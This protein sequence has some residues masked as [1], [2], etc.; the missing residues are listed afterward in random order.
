[1]KNKSLVFVIIVLFIG[2]IECDELE[3]NVPDEVVFVIGEKKTKELGFKNFNISTESD[4]KNF[5]LTCSGDKPVKWITHKTEDWQYIFDYKS[6]RNGSKYYST[7]M[8]KSA[9]NTIT[10]YFNCSYIGEEGGDSK[11][12]Y[13]YVH[14]L[15]AD[16]VFLRQIPY[17][18][19]FKVY[20]GEPIRIDCRT[21]RPDIEVI[22]Y[23]D[24]MK[25]SR[26]L[27]KFDP[28]VGIILEDL[29]DFL[30]QTSIKEIKCK[31][32]FS[33]DEELNFEPL[34]SL[35][36]PS[37]ENHNSSDYLVGEEIALNCSMYV[38]EKYKPDFK[39]ILPN[40]NAIGELKEFRNRS[41]FISIL[42]IKNASL[43]DSGQYVCT[44][45]V[46]NLLE[47][48]TTKNIEIHE[49]VV[50]KFLDKNESINNTQIVYEGG[51]FIW[52]VRFEGYTRNLKYTFYNPNG[53]LF[54][55]KDKRVNVTYSEKGLLRL[56]IEKVT[57]EDFGNYSVKLEAPNG[58][59]DENHVMLIVIPIPN[60]KFSEISSLLPPDKN[61][62]VTLFFTPSYFD[63]L[64]PD[65]ICKL[66]AVCLTIIGDCAE[67]NVSKVNTKLEKDIG[68]L[69]RYKAV[70]SIRP[71]TSGKLWCEVWSGDHSIY[72]ETY[73][74]VSDKTA[75]L[76]V[77]V[78]TENAF[79]NLTRPGTLET[80]NATE[81]DNI[82][83]A[84]FALGSLYYFNSF[85]SSEKT[86]I[87]DTKLSLGK[88]LNIVNISLRKDWF[89][90]CI[91]QT[92]ITNIIEKISFRIDVDEKIAPSVLPSS[93]VS[94]EG[95]EI[96][97]KSP[98]PFFIACYVEGRPKPKIT[99]LKDGENID[100]IIENN[101]EVSMRDDNQILEF[102]F[103]RTKYAGKYE[104]SIENRVEHIQPFANVI[105]EDEASALS[106]KNLRISIVS[107]IIILIISFSFVIFLA[108]KIKKNKNIRND[109]LQL[110]LFLLRE[111]KARQLNKEC[112]LE[113]QA[114]L[115]P[116]DHSYEVE[117]E[118]ITLGKQLDAGAFG[119]VLMAQVKGL[120][121]KES[122]TR[123]AIK[124]CKYEGD[125]THIRA[126]IVELKIMIHLGKHLNIVNLMGAHTSN[127]DKGELWILVEYCKY[128]NLLKLIQRAKNKFINQ[129]NSVTSDIDVG[130]TSP[131]PNDP[132]SPKSLGCS[133]GYGETSK[134]N[135]DAY[136][137]S[138]REGS[139]KIGQSMGG[140]PSATSNAR[141]TKEKQFFPNSSAAPSGDKHYELPPTDP[142]PRKESSISDSEYDF[143]YSLFINSDMMAYSPQP[144]SPAS[145]SMSECQ[146]KSISSDSEN[147]PGISAP[148][149]TTDLLCWA[150]QVANGMEY[151]TSRK[152]LHGD[153]A[154]R[155][156]L[157]ADNNV[158]KICDFGLSREMYKNYVYLKKS[159]VSL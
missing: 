27:Y 94:L 95:T 76:L 122:P 115:L 58:S 89:F 56:S 78:L 124:M 26:L 83:I 30:N 72:E 110:E 149:T 114:E 20:L 154:A 48:N 128:G 51:N 68:T 144:S 44:V 13:I 84:C 100:E 73:L 12:T 113:E 40:I 129:I 96:L 127:V 75:P 77:T 135:P 125:K 3:L 36:K 69:K 16:F 1:M 41:L 57:S 19:T 102:K 54:V 147:I 87:C 46:L 34:I 33:I 10:G 39:W 118:N 9:D 59:Y 37:I 123:V 151:L 74:N 64:K 35:R 7:L 60:L 2:L 21:A 81:G 70:L 157:L 101:V 126:L 66:E 28:R 104:C 91:A 79:V 43:S 152:V 6:A 148:L 120:N 158:V 111:G 61:I 138:H 137:E 8:F 90:E 25:V 63:K 153:L 112:T 146:E 93:N 29:I 97:V 108:I 142:S 132:L 117:R 45:S 67:F 107:F 4:F 22:L 139:M 71:S 105:I 50:V 109:M 134:L 52:N 155:N 150:W 98:F 159:S 65:V 88:C 62:N 131:F 15:K 145:P 55:H 143:T 47:S 17:S 85:N 86:S 31:N 53:N 18:E 11:S 103:A 119:R 136:L 32:N 38:N 23:I 82:N 116:Y 133:I 140:H 106:E 141:L 49:N 5:E 80:I 42:I 14:D 156:L 121:G 99:W 24:D 92:R 130:R